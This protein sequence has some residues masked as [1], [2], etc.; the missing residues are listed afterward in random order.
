MLPR[1]P[2]NPALP[3]PTD[4]YSPVSF[5]SVRHRK[6]QSVAHPSRERS[7]TTSDPPTSSRPSL[8]RSFTHT[9]KRTDS[10][11][12]SGTR[13]SGGD[14]AS[15]TSIS[16][17][18][19]SKADKENGGTSGAGTPKKRMSVSHSV[20]SWMDSLGTSSR[21]RKN[22]SHTTPVQQSSKGNF[23]SLGD[24]P[25]REEVEDDI[26]ERKLERTPRGP[27][28]RDRPAPPLPPRRSN[29]Y[30]RE[31]TLKSALMGNESRESYEYEAG[32][33][34]SV[35]ELKYADRAEVEV[36]GSSG[37][38][39]ART[40]S[41]TSSRAGG[42]S[43]SLSNARSGLFGS[44]AGAKNGSAEGTERTSDSPSSSLLQDSAPAAHNRTPSRGANGN[45]KKYPSNP[46]SQSSPE[47]SRFAFN[48]GYD[49][50]AYGYGDLQDD[51]EPFGD[52]HRDGQIVMRAAHDVFD[53]QSV[54][55]SPHPTSTT[56]SFN[57]V[58]P[59]LNSSTNV[60][61]RPPP[62]IPFRPPS[63]AKKPPPPPPARRALS[64]VN[65][66]TG[67]TG[68]VGPHM[69]LPKIPTRGTDE[70]EESPFGS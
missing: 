59:N 58:N 34:A 52:P 65:L 40:R 60:A 63:S 57:N 26:I 13:E 62:P 31:I 30:G 18:P 23:Q 24:E 38:S 55:P 32:A 66:G 4:A 49:D 27:S 53:Q 6:S 9:R 46:R 12:T 33:T 35:E 45:S 19:T 16:N 54:M 15:N 1:E 36:G 43:F 2:T 7:H 44:G 3:S 17:A 64:N 69:M 11:N 47:L 39:S 70:D 56:T 21:S 25:M 61:S 50:E 28:T 5:S 67:T 8:P 42:G 41:R 37:A 48:E 10:L 20:S 29:D 22:S 14:A 51:E 68:T